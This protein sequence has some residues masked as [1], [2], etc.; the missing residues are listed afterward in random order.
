M[1]APRRYIEGTPILTGDVFITISGRHT[2]PVPVQDYT[3]DRKCTN[4]LR[5]WAAW[6]IAEAIAEAKSRGREDL[7]RVWSTED[8]K[9][10]PMASAQGMWDYTFEYAEGVEQDRLYAAQQPRMFA[11]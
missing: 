4:S 9:N 7:A 3:T 1:S 10:L 11:P 5:R 2:N 8:P 6:K